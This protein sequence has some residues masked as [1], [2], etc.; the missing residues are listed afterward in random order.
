MEMHRKVY[1]V[2]TF[3]KEKPMPFIAYVAPLLVEVNFQKD[4]YIYVEGEHVN[5]IYFI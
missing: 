1:Q 2:I 4:Q 5:F 3:F